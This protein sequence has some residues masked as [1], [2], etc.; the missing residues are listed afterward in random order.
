MV[1]VSDNTKDPS[2]QERYFALLGDAF[3][4]PLQTTAFEEFLDTAHTYFVGVGDSKDMAPDFPRQRG[5]D[6]ALDAHTNRLIEV[7][8]A[9]LEAEARNSATPDHYHAIL[10]IDA[11]SGRVEGNDAARALNLGKLPGQL[12]ELA[13]DHEAMQ[14]I[15]STLYREKGDR[16]DRIILA[17]V[18]DDEPR[19]CLGLVQRAAD[20]DDTV[21]VSLSY[22]HWSDALLNRLGDAFGLTGAETDVLAG[23]LKQQSQRE[24]AEDRGRSIETVKG[25]SKTILRKTGCTR[26]ADVVRLSASIAYLLRQMPNASGAQEADLTD[27]RTPREDL[28]TIKRGQREIS[29]LKQG[30]GRRA[31]LFV[32]A[33]IMGPYLHPQT[34]Q[35]LLAEDCCIIAPSRPGYGY[36]SPPKTREDFI[37]DSVDDALAVLDHE[38]I[39][40]VTIVAHQLGT[41]HA[42]RI[43]AALGQRAKALVIINGSIPIDDTYFASMERRTRFAGVAIRHAPSVLRMAT[44][45][46]IRNFKRKGVEGFLRDRY[47]VLDVDREALEESTTMRV[48]AYGVFHMSEQGAA[49]FINDQTTKLKDWSDDF[50]SPSCQRFWLQPGACRIIHPDH[51]ERY[52]RTHSEAVFETVPGGGSLFLYAEPQKSADFILRAME[53]VGA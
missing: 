28:H 1:Q 25:Q 52:V 42:H 37:Q 4:V 49:A 11:R 20:E 26:M 31:I 6:D 15:K 35:T 45:L 18:G 38:G 53:T 32:H 41:S 48:H 34:I 19:A 9:A 40:D 23:Y 46:G 51:V 22:I 8:D 29:Y 30:A 33:L 7:F 3:A 14:Q 24:I 43:A 16:E 50:K 17:L 27:W 39:K 12:D 13:L 5:T 2:A 47:A 44:E 21:L 10:T 36:T